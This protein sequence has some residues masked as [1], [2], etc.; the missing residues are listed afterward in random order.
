M[1][2]ISNSCSRLTHLT[3]LSY[4]Y[5]H[6]YACMS[7]LLCYNVYTCAFLVKSRHSNQTFPAHLTLFNRSS[8][9]AFI[10]VT[11]MRAILKIKF[12]FPSSRLHFSLDSIQYWTLL[13]LSLLNISPCQFILGFKESNNPLSFSHELLL[14]Y[15]CFSSS[16]YFYIKYWNFY[17][18]PLHFNFFHSFL[19]LAFY[20]YSFIDYC[21][22][23]LLPCTF[24]YHVFLFG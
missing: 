1:W 22:N 20:K 17:S 4:Y 15:S 21:P 13:F 11:L 8:L 5:N 18:S 7:L 2:V 14:K 16:W 24:L 19:N 6:W 10:T 12:Y 23:F 3:K 9:K